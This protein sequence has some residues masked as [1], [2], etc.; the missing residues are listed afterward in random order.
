MFYDVIGEK[1]IQNM[2]DD[3][4]HKVYYIYSRSLRGLKVIVLK[5]N[6]SGC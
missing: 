3:S 5:K 1:S 4:A 6:E 2:H